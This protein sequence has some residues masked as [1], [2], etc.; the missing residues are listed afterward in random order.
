MHDQSLH[1][2][3]IVALLGALQEAQHVHSITE[4][5]QTH[6][7]PTLPILDQNLCTSE[8][9]IQELENTPV[10]RLF[11]V[12]HTENFIEICR[13]T[14]TEVQTHSQNPIYHLL[15][16]TVVWIFRMYFT[17]T[18]SSYNDLYFVFRLSLYLKKAQCRNTN[19]SRS[20]VSQH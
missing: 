14:N 11:H 18:N 17:K 9:R 13:P 8:S 19:L 10:Y 6:T 16:I 1:N 7:T 12:P 20:E 5:S 4:I 2:R 3:P 15:I